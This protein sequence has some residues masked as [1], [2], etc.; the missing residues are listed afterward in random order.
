MK[1]L[2]ATV[3]VTLFASTLAVLGV[4]AFPHQASAAPGDIWIFCEDRANICVID[5]THDDYTD[6]YLGRLW[7][8][9]IEQ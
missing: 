8:I 9:G 3:K 1:K 5:E 6:I 2:I 7:G 4:S